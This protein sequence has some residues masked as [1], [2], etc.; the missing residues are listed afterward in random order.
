MV[1][2]GALF[3]TSVL[4]TAGFGM[5]AGLPAAV[6]FLLVVAVQALFLV[7]VLRAVG[8][9]ENERNLIA[10]ALGLVVPIAAIGVISE[11]PLALSLLPDA[12]FVLFLRM[13]WKQ[14]AG[15]GPVRSLTSCV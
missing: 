14:Y 13:L 15:N 7:G 9:R 1:V 11:L 12:A 8:S 10:L 3:Y 5:G 4:L 6:D 2:L